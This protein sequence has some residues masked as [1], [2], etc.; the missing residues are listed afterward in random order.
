MI[1]AIDGID[2]IGKTTICDLLVEEFNGIKIKGVQDLYVDKLAYASFS[3]E[4]KFLY[5]VA[6]FCDSVLK[7]RK[8]NPDKIIF[9]DKSVYTTIAF[10][11]AFGN[12][13]KIENLFDATIRP[14]LGIFLSS[15]NNIWRERLLERESLCW[16]EQEVVNN[17]ELSVKIENEYKK[18]GLDEI[19]ISDVITTKNI[20][21]DLINKR[22]NN[23]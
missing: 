11:N 5:Y 7:A 15:P 3:I 19:I 1:I 20:I 17:K 22:L 23:E 18:L 12:K 10:H 2:G 4:I 14:D 6:S 13:L 21:R 16:Y 9:L 8:N